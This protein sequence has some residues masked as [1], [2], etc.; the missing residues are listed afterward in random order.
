MDHMQRT[1][2]RDGVWV[3]ATQVKTPRRPIN[4]ARRAMYKAM[5]DRPLTKDDLWLIDD[6]DGYVDVSFGSID[7][8]L[9][10]KMRGGK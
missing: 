8:Q 5:A 9:L 2:Y 1:R 10:R 6:S 3:V 4:E 7:N